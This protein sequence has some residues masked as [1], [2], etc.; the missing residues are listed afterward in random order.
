M[1]L[2]ACMC[3]VFSGRLFVQPVRSCCYFNHNIC[4][5]SCWTLSCLCV[6][7]VTHEDRNRSASAP[8]L[9][10]V[11]NTHPYAIE[12]PVVCLTK[13]ANYW[14]FCCV[15]AL[16]VFVHCAIILFSLPH[17]RSCRAPTSAPLLSTQQ[18]AVLDVDSPLCASP[19]CVLFTHLLP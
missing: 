7:F 3:T 11:W 8:M 9:G 4:R 14:I 6:C 15:S 10:T 19:A 5:L 12:V 18:T 17:V 1:A 16:S 2:C 13:N